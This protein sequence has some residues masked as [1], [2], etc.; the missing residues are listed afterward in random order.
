M[1]HLIHDGWARC[2]GRWA[3]LRLLAGFNP[4]CK[5]ISSGKRHLGRTEGGKENL[6]AKTKRDLW[7]FLFTEFARSCLTKTG[8]SKNNDFPMEVEISGRDWGCR[9]NLNARPDSPYTPRASSSNIFAME[10]DAYTSLDCTSECTQCSVTYKYVRRRKNKIATWCENWL[11]SSNLRDFQRLK[12]A[13]L[14]CI[15]HFSDS[16]MGLCVLFM[17]KIIWGFPAP[18]GLSTMYYTFE[19]L[20]ARIVCLSLFLMSGSMQQSLR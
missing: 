18:A 2:H 16:A 5:T 12:T 11:N 13:V 19:S 10:C 14:Q 6:L 20:C 4:V 8:A 1:K 9:Y 15:H 17:A 7:T 3:F